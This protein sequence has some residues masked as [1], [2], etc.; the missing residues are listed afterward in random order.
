MGR[1]TV[2]GIHDD[3]ADSRKVTR[4]G[5]SEVEVI[6]REMVLSHAR[7]QL[8]L[9]ID[10]AADASHYRRSEGLSCAILLVGSDKQGSS[11]RVERTVPAPNEKRAETVRSWRLGVAESRIRVA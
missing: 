1:D 10:A 3:F 6:A 5:R 4:D 7:R 8:L 2:E 11:T 9:P